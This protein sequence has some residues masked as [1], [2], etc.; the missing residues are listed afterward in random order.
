MCFVFVLVSLCT[1]KQGKQESTNKGLHSEST[2]PCLCSLPYSNTVVLYI[3]SSYTPFFI[4]DC[5]FAYCCL[6]FDFLSLSST[7]PSMHPY[8]SPDTSALCTQTLF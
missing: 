2:V 5:L 3:V 1:L 6:Q 4:F 8:F 7:L